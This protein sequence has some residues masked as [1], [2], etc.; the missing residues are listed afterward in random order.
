MSEAALLAASKGVDE[1]LADDGEADAD[2]GVPASEDDNDD[3][4]L[5]AMPVEQEDEMPQ[6]VM[7]AWRQVHRHLVRAVAIGREAVAAKKAQRRFW[8]EEICANLTE[9]GNLTQTSVWKRPE[10]KEASAKKTTPAKAK[11]TAGR[12]RKKPTTPDSVPGSVL[13]RIKTTMI[14]DRKKSRSPPAGGSTKKIRLKLPTKTNR[15]AAEEAA[16]HA[17]ADIDEA[18]EDD[19]DDEEAAAEVE[20]DEEENEKDETDD[21]DE[22]DGGEEGEDGEEEH[23]SPPHLQHKAH[24]PPHEYHHGPWSGHPQGYMVSVL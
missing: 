18:S 8:M 16:A 4:N 3:E 23:Y 9:E 1:R 10:K 17:T 22:E 7:E 13:K 2:E 6:S 5:E 12:K 14:D 20:E 24:Y 21:E 15:T 11:A 19:D